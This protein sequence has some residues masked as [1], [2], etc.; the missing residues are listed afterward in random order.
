MPGWWCGSC[1]TTLVDHFTLTPCTAETVAVP[2]VLLVSTVVLYAQLKRVKLLKH[3]RSYL[4][5]GDS[6]LR[7][8]TVAA[9]VFAVAVS[10][11]VWLVHYSVQRKAAFHYLYETA[12]A[13]NWCAALVSSIVLTRSCINVSRPLHA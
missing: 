6:G 2:L 4:G 3:H 10:H 7:E 1:D 8:A 5:L 9:L 11:I 12:L 13:L